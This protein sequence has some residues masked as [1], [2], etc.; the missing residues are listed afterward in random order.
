[1][2]LRWPCEPGGNTGTFGP[3]VKGC[4]VLLEGEGNS[5][6]TNPNSRLFEPLF[7]ERFT[8]RDIPGLMAGPVGR[9]VDSHS[10]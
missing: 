7:N 3:M 5:F 4:L 8:R 9:Y 1:M 10:A 6:V 2:L